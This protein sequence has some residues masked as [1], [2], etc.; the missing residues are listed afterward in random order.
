MIF[1]KQKMSNNIMNRNMGNFFF[2]LPFSSNI[3]KEKHIPVKY[4]PSNN[5]KKIFPWFTIFGELI[6][7]KLKTSDQNYGSK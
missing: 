3:S 4:F 5:F 2:E 1:Q 6:F 7:Q